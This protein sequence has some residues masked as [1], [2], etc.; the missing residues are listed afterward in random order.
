ML[1]SRLI[2][3]QVTALIRV[4]MLCPAYLWIGS[5]FREKTVYPTQ[6][7]EHW[8]EEYN[9]LKTASERSDWAAQKIEECK[10]INAVRV[11]SGPEIAL[12]PTLLCSTPN[13]AKIG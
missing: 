11:I 1:K 6:L 13:F 3:N 7:I 9:A 5:A 4:C 12:T 10:A 8:E 2:L